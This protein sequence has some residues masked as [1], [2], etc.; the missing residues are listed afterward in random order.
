MWGMGI[1]RGREVRLFTVCNVLPEHKPFLLVCRTK[2]PTVSVLSGF[3]GFVYGCIFYALYV[4]SSL[5]HA[6]L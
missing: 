6:L 4:L 5:S 3:L 1:F 2:Y